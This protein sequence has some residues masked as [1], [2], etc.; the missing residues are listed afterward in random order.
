LLEWTIVDPSGSDVQLSEFEPRD[1][2]GIGN[3]RADDLLEQRCSSPRDKLEFVKG[4][5]C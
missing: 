5:L 3:R 2:T 1:L 4:I